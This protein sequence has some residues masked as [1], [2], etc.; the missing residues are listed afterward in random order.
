MGRNFRS[1]D[2][3]FLAR[4]SNFVTCSAQRTVIT[5]YLFR[6]MSFRALP[7]LALRIYDQLMLYCMHFHQGAHTIKLFPAQRS[8]CLN[9][10]ALCVGETTL[11]SH[12][13]ATKV[14]RTW[15]FTMKAATVRQRG[16]DTMLFVG[17]IAHYSRGL[18][19]S[20]F[21]IHGI[22][23][24]KVTNG[25]KIRKYDSRLTLPSKTGSGQN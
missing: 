18:F 3:W 6:V 14:R 17:R 9:T 2:G 5:H 22:K 24:Y 25:E 7:R 8:P 13:G 23:Y 15:D 12:C 16:P 20:S 4:P 19:G 10:V 21:L 1:A 11:T